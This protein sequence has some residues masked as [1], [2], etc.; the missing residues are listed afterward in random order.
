M[1]LAELKANSPWQGKKP[2]RTF[3][4][5]TNTRKPANPAGSVEVKSESGQPNPD[6]CTKWP[7]CTRP[8]GHHGTHV[9]KPRTAQSAAAVKPAKPARSV[10]S[11]EPV[12]PAHV[13]SEAPTAL[14]TLPVCRYSIGYYEETPDG[15]DEIKLSGRSRA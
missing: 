8:V 13:V 14:A 6:T 12:A 9:G 3:S 15:P 4:D 7:G 1:T 2:Q 11:V 5:S 10:P